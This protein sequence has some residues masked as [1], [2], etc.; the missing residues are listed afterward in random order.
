MTI[1]NKV[2]RGVIPATSESAKLAGPEVL[3]WVLHPEASGSSDACEYG[4]YHISCLRAVQRS[5]KAGFDTSGS[6]IYFKAPAQL[7]YVGC[8]TPFR[9]HPE[10]LIFLC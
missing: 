2:Q 8:G 1:R 7:T 4:M 6:R 5:R 10:L 9:Y 3:A